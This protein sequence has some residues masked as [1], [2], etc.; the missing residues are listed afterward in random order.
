M[1]RRDLSPLVLQNV[2]HRALQHSGSAA[3]IRRSGTL[4]A[5]AMWLAL[6]AVVGNIV[7]MFS[8]LGPG[9]AALGFAGVMTF[10]LFILVTGITMAIG[11][12]DAAATAV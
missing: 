3:A 4:P 9:A 12:A 1:R 10:A 8:D 5:Y 11:K 6:L 7:T 2:T